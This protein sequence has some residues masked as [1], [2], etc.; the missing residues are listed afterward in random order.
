M[1]TLMN[2][3]AIVTGASSGIGRSTARL[4]AQEGA[5]VVVTAR[6][7]DA[8]NALVAEIERAG[9]RAIAV[10]GDIRDEVLAQTLVDTAIGRF[11]GL[12]IAFNNAGTNGEMGPTPGL[13]LEGWN[14]TLATNLTAA[15]LGA[16]Y[17]IPAMLDR[18]GG[19][20]IFTSTF[21]GYTAGMPGVAAYAASKS[22]LI[23]LTQA[24]ATE[25]GPKGIRVNALLPGG[26][27]TP[28]A[29]A[30]VSTPEALAFVEGLHAL[31]RRARPE[32]IARSA[33]YLASDASSFTTGTALLVD[34][35]VS[36]NRT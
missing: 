21:V 29:E 7:S 6:R 24:L 13:S 26:T 15:F 23:G 16:K 11:G 27:D 22:G 28:L 5:N 30:W 36:I 2:K 12:D 35:G 25:F 19:S 18:G 31:K 3:T 20:L 4:F 10:A 32:E 14:E 8:L 34:G 9:G 33:L 17:Q 1:T